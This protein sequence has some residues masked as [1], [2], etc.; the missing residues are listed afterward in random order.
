MAQRVGWGIALLFHDRGTR[1]GWV[2]S[3]TPRPYFTPGKD[4]ELIVQEAGWAPGPVCTAQNLAPP[5]S[6]PW[7]VQPV[8]SRYTDCASPTHRRTW[9]LVIWNFRKFKSHD[10][11]WTL[12]RM[13]QGSQKLVLRRLSTSC[14]VR[15]KRKRN[16]QCCHVICVESYCGICQVGRRSLCCS[17]NWRKCWHLVPPKQR[18]ATHVSGEL[19]GCPTYTAVM[20]TDDKIPARQI[21]THHTEMPSPKKRQH[22]AVVVPSASNH[23]SEWRTVSFVRKFLAFKWTKQGCEQTCWLRIP[24]HMRAQN[25]PTSFR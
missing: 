6:D 22:P 11:P 21:F 9:R 10:K 24:S 15:G 25:N 14:D 8:V 3:N 16:V 4:P 20:T 12:L 23:G 5:G 19:R 18:S 17:T 1:R 7:T 13:S 2:V